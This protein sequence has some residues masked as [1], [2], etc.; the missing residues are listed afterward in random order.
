MSIRIH[1]LLSLVLL[2]LSGLSSVVMADSIDDVL[3]YDR[4]Y[5]YGYCYNEGRQSHRSVSGLELFED[6]FDGI[7]YRLDKLRDIRSKVNRHPNLRLSTVWEDITDDI[8]V[9]AERTRNMLF[10]AYSDILF[11]G[12]KKTPLKVKLHRHAFQQLMGR[13]DAYHAKEIEEK[14]EGV[15][16]F[17]REA[18][19]LCAYTDTKFSAEEFEK[20]CQA[21]EKILG[22]ENTDTDLTQT[23]R[24]DRTTQDIVRY[25]RFKHTKLIDLSQ[26]LVD[27]AM[28]LV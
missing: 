23:E 2:G 1:K 10:M 21:K 24:F 13:V 22:V 20:I 16:A 19:E 5:D 27:C 26:G 12:D 11:D 6:P 7:P 17:C 18:M 8:K 9:S 25:G 14:G 3:D 15:R 4:D 28:N